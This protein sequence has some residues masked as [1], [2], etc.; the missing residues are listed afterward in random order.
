MPSRSDPLIQEGHLRLKHCRHGWVLYNARDTYVGRSFDRYGEYSEFECQTFARLIRPGQTV[1]DVGA[2]IGGHT[3][4][5]ARLVGP[6]G[7]VAAF[8]PQRIV[9][10]MLCANV[11]LNGFSRV[12]TI[13]AACGRSLGQANV[14]SLDYQAVNNVGGLSLVGAPEG[15]SVPTMP[16]D[17]VAA[18][19]CHFIKIDVEGMEGEVIAGAEKTIAKW[20]PILYVENDRA[21]R[22]AALIEQ[23]MALGYRLYWHLPRLYNSRNFFG[24]SENVFGDIVSVNMLCVPREVGIEVSGTEITSPADSWKS[25]S[26][27]FG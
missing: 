14:P 7:L 3:L 13:W 5:F 23:I 1:Y 8:E 18:P 9:F 20:R 6:S 10:Q 26:P 25:A 2:N 12:W 27:Q 16:L 15:E 24:E 4:A 17:D 21:E 11:A 22:S 19:A